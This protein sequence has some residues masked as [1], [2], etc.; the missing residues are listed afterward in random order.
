MNILS[1][2]ARKKKIQYFLKTIPRDARILEVGSGT[3]WVSHYLKSNGF[4]NYISIDIEPPADIVGDINNWQALGL[5]AGQF[6]YIIA[7]EVVEHVD[8]FQAC[9]DLLR[10]G[11]QMFLTTP[12]PQ[13]DWV[14]EILERLR[15]NQKRT[16]PHDSLVH[17]KRVSQFSNKQ[18]RIVGGL[19]QWGI[20][21]K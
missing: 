20:F 15:L 17:L 3:G 7:F 19:S 11:G 4:A 10:N 9:A 12:L 14:M 13:M 6:D 2:L 18:I 8:C 21:T 16:S 1:E 5:D